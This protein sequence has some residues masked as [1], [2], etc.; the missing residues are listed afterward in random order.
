MKNYQYILLTAIILISVAIPA[1][2][3]AQ[4]AGNGNAPGA[5]GFQ[6]RQGMTSFD[7]G[8]MQNMI[9]NMFKEQ[10][11]ISDD[12]WTVIGPKVMNVLTLSSQ[13]RANPMRMMR[14]GRPGG[15]GGQATPDM[16]GQRQMRNRMPGIF[17]QGEEDENMQ[18]LQKL[19]ED[20]NADASQIKQLVTKVR[21][22]REKSQRELAAAKKELRELLTVRQE[23]ILISM[24]L[25]D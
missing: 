6:G 10:L 25:L 20:K 19:L 17:G 22:A 8:Q 16:Q 15:P 9:S 2:A 7:P 11:G 23:A 12:E 14:A 18:A 24:G 13:S 1:A 5:S 21:K 3:Q 4:P